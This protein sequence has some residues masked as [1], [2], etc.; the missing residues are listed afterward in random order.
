[1]A[2]QKHFHT[3]IV[4]G[5]LNLDGGSSLCTLEFAHWDE[6]LYFWGR[7]NFFSQKIANFKHVFHD[8]QIQKKLKLKYVR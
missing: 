4:D 7:Y 6:N 5:A 1:M 8:T 3:D 2:P